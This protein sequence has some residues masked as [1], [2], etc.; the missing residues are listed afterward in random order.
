VHGPGLLLQF[1]T[2]PRGGLEKFKNS[3]WRADPIRGAQFRDPNDPDQTLF[4]FTPTADLA[5]LRR[6]LLAH[7]VRSVAMLSSS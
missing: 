7:L 6:L 4:D 2:N 1:G 5:P 3:L